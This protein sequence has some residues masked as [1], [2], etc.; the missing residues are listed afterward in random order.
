MHFLTKPS[1]W[2]SRVRN[3]VKS[4]KDD[5]GQ[6]VGTGPK[7]VQEQSLITGF[8]HYCTRILTRGLSAFSINPGI[9][10]KIVIN[11]RVGRD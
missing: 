6:T 3:T 11:P 8:D 10:L 9:L 2:V 7:R 4:T 5:V 1:E